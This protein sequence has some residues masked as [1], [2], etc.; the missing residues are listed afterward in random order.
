MLRRPLSFD[1]WGF[2]AKGTCVQDPPLLGRF[3]FFRIT[4]FLFNFP[5][6]SGVSLKILS[7][8]DKKYYT[9]KSNDTE[10]IDHLY[11][12]EGPRSEK[13]NV[14]DIIPEK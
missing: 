4:N 9:G 2:V 12:R 5:P 13:I 8:S 1:F 10:L 7:F 11:H 3:H 14:Q 6:L